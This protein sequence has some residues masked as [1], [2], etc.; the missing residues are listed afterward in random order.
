MLCRSRE[1]RGTSQD[2]PQ[3]QDVVMDKMPPWQWD[4]RRLQDL[5]LQQH[6]LLAQ[7]RKPWAAE[8]RT[9]RHGGLAGLV[10]QHDA[11]KESQRLRRV[12]RRLRGPADDPHG[13]A[14]VQ[15]ELATAFLGLRTS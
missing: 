11:V 12:P 14:H 4:S 1:Q 9:L 6:T 15:H 2:E 8:T 10:R 3:R 13:A 5:Q 7:T